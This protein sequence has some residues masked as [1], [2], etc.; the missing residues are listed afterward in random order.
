MR[1]YV[2]IVLVCSLTLPL[3]GVAAATD[4]TSAAIPVDLHEAV[5]RTLAAS[6]T[7]AIQKNAARKTYEIYRATK[8][9]IFPHV[10]GTVGL[11]R[12][13]DY[14]RDPLGMMQD[15][16]AGYGVEASQLLWSFGKVGAAIRAADSA[17]QASV[18]SEQSSRQDTVRR[19]KEAYYAALLARETLA[20]AAAS[21]ENAR[22]NKRLLQERS[23]GGRASKRDLIKIE[24]DI[25]ARVPVQSRAEAQVVA[26]VATLK[27][28]LGIA[29]EQP[30]RL[31]DK[32]S[33]DYPELAYAPLERKM[34][35]EEPTLQA[36]DKN[37][38]FREHAVRAQKGAYYPEI[39]GF[40]GW[41]R[42]GGA[43]TWPVGQGELDDYSL[44]G[45]KM[46]V[47]L[48]TGGDTQAT[49]AQARLDAQTAHLE[50]SR[51]EKDL[52]V[53]LY[54]AVS[55]YR[56]QRRTLAANTEALRLSEELLAMTR[57]MFAS[58]QVSAADLNDAE[59]LLTSQRLGRLQTMYTLNVL[60]ARIDQ[61]TNS[62]ELPYD[63]P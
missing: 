57:A 39:A 43:D 52:R 38:Q 53:A 61:L 63:H 11:T 17:L 20:V 12:N 5:R 37:V 41:Q 58:G 55:E 42:Q 60:K 46:T 1:R 21:S 29:Q 34:L 22:A 45:I 40:A 56:E 24:A 4:T 62:G 7:L 18:F 48:W 3:V 6:E 44:V 51:A 25:A 23:A 47:P 31:T 32:F 54:A 19:A 10:S 26:A 14:A 2:A 50:R 8:S 16:E 49:V 35:A 30:I 59:L 9:V 28:L 27:S 13:L 15:Y 36:L 33:D